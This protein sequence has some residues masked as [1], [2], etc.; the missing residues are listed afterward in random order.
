MKKFI[1]GLKNFFAFLVLTNIGRIGGSVILSFA[2]LAIANI[3]ES[4]K[5]YNFFS[6][7]A[8][9]FFSITFAH[10]AVMMYYAWIKNGLFVLIKNIKDKKKKK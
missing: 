2:S 7:L 5:Y 9:C 10:F 8:I 1:N 3:C 6:I 4:V